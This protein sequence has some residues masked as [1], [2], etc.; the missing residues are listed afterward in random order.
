[1][2]NEFIIKGDGKINGTLNVGILGTGTSVNNLGIDTNGFIVSETSGTN[3]FTTGATLNGT[4][5]E[6]DRTDLL[7]AYNV[8]LSG[9]T[10]SNFANTDLILTENRAHELNGNNLQIGEGAS[11]FSG[12]NFSAITGGFLGIAPTGSFLSHTVNRYVE[13]TSTKISFYNGNNVTDITSNDVTFNQN[14]DNVDLRVEGETDL[15]L[16]FTDASTDRVGI[17]TNTPTEKLDVNGNTK[18]NGT[19]NI[20]T[21]GTGTSVNNLGIDTN[22]FIVTGTTSTGG[23]NKYSASISFTGGTTQTV[24]H[25]LNDTDVVVQLKDSTGKLIIPNEVNNY[26]SN[27][28]DIEVSSTETY[29][30]IIIG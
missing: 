10:S 11:V 30:I 22:G 17:G 21:L 28:V 20:S 16:F 19:L 24:T 15:N 13:V 8:E 3:T 25:N 18:I 26:T 6:F 14:R 9:F 4:V 12:S 29:R 23:V 2:A 27:T 7:N 5:L 1:M